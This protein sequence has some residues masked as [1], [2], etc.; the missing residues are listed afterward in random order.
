MNVQINPSFFALGL[1]RQDT[2]T[3]MDSEMTLDQ[4]CDL[5]PPDHCEVTAAG[6]DNT[7]KVDADDNIVSDVD[8]LPVSDL[9]DLKPHSTD[10]D[11]PSSP[12]TTD[13]TTQ[14]EAKR[15]GLKEC[16]RNT[17]ATLPIAQPP[18]NLKDDASIDWEEISRPSG[19]PMSQ[20]LMILKNLLIAHAREEAAFRRETLESIRALTERVEELTK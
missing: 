14:R 16:P 18:A 12:A 8:S 2:E 7:A 11:Y 4:L 20:S 3:N 17:R 6:V 19:D 10:V 13:R 1:V 5:R 15:E 9:L